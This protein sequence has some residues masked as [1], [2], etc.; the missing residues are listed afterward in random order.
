MK[1]FLLV[2][3]LLLFLLAFLIPAFY[4]FWHFSW[5]PFN[6]SAFYSLLNFVA[7]LILVFVTA[8][9][10]ATTKHYV[11]LFEQDMKTRQ[12]TQEEWEMRRFLANRLFIIG[13]GFVEVFFA[14]KRELEVFLLQ[15]DGVV[16]SLSAMHRTAIASVTGT[17]TV[18]TTAESRANSLSAAAYVRY[19]E[20]AAEYNWRAQVL[21]QQAKSLLP[22]ELCQDIEIIFHILS[23][24]FDTVEEGRALI[25]DYEKNFQSVC[26][27]VSEIHTLGASKAQWRD[28]TFSTT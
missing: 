18:P 1:R 24:N 22:K 17:G 6:V 10:V 8:A 11:D 14:S 23:R 12:A 27:I 3:C 26:R 5:V 9:Y 21:L 4:V 15:V 2:T 13:D 28:Q 19:N 25:K 7:A 16:Q 20:R